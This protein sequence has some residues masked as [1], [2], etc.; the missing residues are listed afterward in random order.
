[1][2]TVTPNLAVKDP[3]PATSAEAVSPFVSAVVAMADGSGGTAPRL[4]R[5]P[6]TRPAWFGARAY[7]RHHAVRVLH[8]R[9]LV[10][11]G[12][13]SFDRTTNTYSR[14]WV[15]INLPWGLTADQ[16]VVLLLSS[17][18]MELARRAIA[19]QAALAP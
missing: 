7:G 3:K 9:L 1:M 14:D 15:P 8:Q 17:V 11:K 13:P 4:W 2:A 16:Y 19:R 18:T 6:A 10:R 5:A 12:L